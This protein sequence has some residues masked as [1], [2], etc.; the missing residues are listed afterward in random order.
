MESGS[1]MFEGCRSTPLPLRLAKGFCIIPRE[2]SDSEARSMKTQ[3]QLES[4]SLEG[5]K[6]DGWSGGAHANGEEARGI[7]FEGGGPVGVRLG[8]RAETGG[9]FE[10]RCLQANSVSREA[11]SPWLG[12]QGKLQ[13]DIKPRGETGVA[14]GNGE[15]AAGRVVGLESVAREDRG[16]GGGAGE[17][18]ESDESVLQRL[19]AGEHRAMGELWG[20][21]AGLL[22]SQ[23]LRVLHN[24]AEAEDVVIEVFSEV[25]RRSGG[26]HPERARPAAWLVTLVRRRAIDRFRERRSH[27]RAEERLA[28]EREAASESSDGTE[29]QVR[30][31]ELRRLLEHALKRLPD[32]Q[33][34]AVCMVYFDGL[35]QREISKRTRTPIGTVKTRIELGLRKMRERIRGAHLRPRMEVGAGGESFP[36]CSDS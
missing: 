28:H 17:S 20:R 19:N 3:L 18:D 36:I 13:E 22:F 23:A 33:R 16:N 26:Y 2:P 12:A 4:E 30:L 5:A 34:E 24:P 1:L 11:A 21:Y 27:E 6:G 14:L 9:G 29:A 35:T 8:R 10:E 15:T 25:W 32:R 31:S 7:I